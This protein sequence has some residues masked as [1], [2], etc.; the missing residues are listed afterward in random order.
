MPPAA[1]D[2][3]PLGVTFDGVTFCYDQDEI[4]LDDVTFNLAPGQILGLLGRTGSGKT[5]I[6]RLLFRLYDPTLGA[7][8][9]GGQDIRHATLDDL[10]N[11][12][13]IVTQNVQLFQASIRDNLTFFN[14]EIPDA[15]ILE[16]LE[17][18]ELD[19][20]L[21]RQ[22]HGLDTRLVAGGQN[23]SAGEA[24]LLAFTRIFLK[25]P[26]LVILDE[27]S[28]RLDPLTEQLIERAISRL[29]QDRTAIIVAHRLATVQRADRIVILQDG[30]IVEQ[31]D[32]VALVAN[33]ES[34]F[35]QLLRAGMEQ[36][37]A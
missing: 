13:G 23:L 5:T 10:R 8:R 15:R 26:G 17:M 33:G 6:T 29:L 12:V 14:P 21:T 9:L 28:S 35:S 2:A 34:R 20:W 24:Q 36:V 18:V 31:G 37:L 30:R 16:T 3:G 1:L 4:I 19:S 27:A 7:I 25:D 32:R 22:S 11:R